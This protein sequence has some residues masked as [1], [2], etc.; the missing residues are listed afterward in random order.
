[1]LSSLLKYSRVWG[2]KIFAEDAWGSRLWIQII[3]VCGSPLGSDVMEAG[4]KSRMTVPVQYTGFSTCL[5][6]VP[7]TN[8][9]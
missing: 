5:G 3:K 9:W 2:L 1:M 7:I 4:G 8:L 6:R